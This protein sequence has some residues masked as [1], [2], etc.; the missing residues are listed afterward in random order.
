MSKQALSRLLKEFS[1]KE[2]SNKSVGGSSKPYRKEYLDK[3]KQIFELGTVQH[4]ADQ[5]IIEIEMS[6]PDILIA[7]HV[8]QADIN[9]AASALRDAF[10]AKVKPANVLDPVAGLVTY[11]TYDPMAKN[12][13]AANKVA[14]DVIQKAAASRGGNADKI[15]SSLTSPDHVRTNAE[16]RF[17]DV[18]YNK[19][20]NPVEA[21]RSLK[22][23]GK[24]DNDAY[25]TFMTQYMDITSYYTNGQ[26]IFDLSVG[27]ELKLRSR[28]GNEAAGTELTRALTDQIKD[29]INKAIVNHN[30]ADQTGSDSYKEALI[31]ELTNIVVKGGG[32]GKIAKPNTARNSARETKKIP[33]K[34]KEFKPKPK[35]A[36]PKAKKPLINLQAIVNY[37]N[38]RLPEAVRANMNE[39][40][41][42]NRTGRFSESAKIV[43]AQLTPQGF[44]SLAYNYQ[45]SPYDVF[46]PVLGRKPWNTPGRDPKKLIEKSVRDITKE[47]AIGRFYL[48]RA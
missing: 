5:L 12:L 26:K 16:I 24:L 7:G 22:D 27:A 14:F 35:R 2:D 4:I 21:I 1:K 29:S 19:L 37:I 28:K 18:F 30:W 9:N 40:T 11:N 6:D 31:K 17:S 41:L 34:V 20:P 15:S 10:M 13:A 32:K 45:R 36:T 3:N 42:V 33:V 23:F 48:R 38:G 43:G 46:D 8:T 44:P 47:M 39:S 25:E